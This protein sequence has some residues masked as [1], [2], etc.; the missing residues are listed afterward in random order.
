MKLVM[1]YVVCFV[2]QHDLQ[3]DEYIKGIT[4]E[5]FHQC[6]TCTTFEESRTFDTKLDALE[7]LRVN[8]DEDHTYTIVEVIQAWEEDK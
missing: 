3:T 2:E 8:G 4:T 1:K 7:Y 6:V 5:D